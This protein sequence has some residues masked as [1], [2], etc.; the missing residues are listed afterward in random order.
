MKMNFWLF[1]KHWIAG[2]LLLIGGLFLYSL[3]D[4]PP[5]IDDAWLGEHAYWQAKLGFVKSELM[6]GIT[7]QEDRFLLGHKLLSL[8]GALMIR[9]FGFSLVVL[10][11]VS[12]AYLLLF[13]LLFYWHAFRKLLSPPEFWFTV[14]ILLVNAQLFDYAFVFRP[15]TMLMAYGFLSYVCLDKA[16]S[17]P[18]GGTGW[19]ALAGVASGLCVSSHLNGVIFVIAGFLLLVVNRRFLPALLFG[20]SAIPSAAVYFYDFTSR[21]N[22]HF[23]L[24]QL[25]ETPAFERPQGGSSLWY[26][27]VNLAT[28]QQRYFHSPLEI[29]LT[30]LVIIP[31]LV[32]FRS[33]LKHRNLLRYTLFLILTLG[34]FS[35]H[36]TSKYLIP[37]LP[38][39]ALI[40]TIS[41]RYFADLV[42]NK[43]RR[44]AGISNHLLAGVVLGVLAFYLVVN[45]FLDTQL[46]FH[47][48]DPGANHALVEK[49]IHADT[50]TCR[51]IAPMTFI[52]NEITDFSRIQ[53]DLCYTEMQK[54]DPGLSGIRFLDVARSFGTNYII[55]TDDFIHRLGVDSLTFQELSQHGYTRLANQKELVILEHP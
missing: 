5:D 24:Y 32:T 9:L 43:K 29:S 52:F 45:T 27:L 37:V 19:I 17:S 25:H 2:V 48:Y 35:V 44:V 3:V 38:Y 16:L 6:H 46:A 13:L 49:Y 11:S 28:E 40:I 33:L 50:D 54:S 4:R 47:K 30:L 51:I 8:Q 12:L 41:F 26:Y 14:L 10:K 18:R 42:S 36:K 20:L 31:A 34:I 15:E 55:L 1:R 53:S 39:L 22:L 23:W 7:H 21:Y